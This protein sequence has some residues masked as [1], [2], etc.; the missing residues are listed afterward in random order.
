MRLGPR[1]TPTVTSMLD[2]SC[3]VGQTT[4]GFG[5]VREAVRLHTRRLPASSVVMIV[6]G[7]AMPVSELRS[8]GTLFGKDT[9]Q[10]GVRVIE[11]ADPAVGLGR[12]T[13]AGDRRPARRPPERAARGEHVSGRTWVD[14]AVLLVLTTLGVI[15]FEPSFA[16]WS[17]LIAGLG[18]MLLGA[19]TGILTGIF[20]VGGI[21]TTL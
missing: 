15:G 3:R 4:G 19:A 1:H 6:A 20:R 14:V 5:S 7:S 9:A 18:G 2:A 17:F 12:R 8:V 10:F 11:G 16:G 13:L 21:L